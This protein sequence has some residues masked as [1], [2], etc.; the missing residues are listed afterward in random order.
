MDRRRNP[1]TPNAGATP[2]SL[3]GRGE[4]LEDFDLLLDRLAA[5]HTEQSMLISGLRGVGKT[6][7]LGQFREHAL[8]KKW[9]TVETEFA[10]DVAFGPRIVQ[11]SRQALF[12]VAPRSRWRAAAHRAAGVLSAFSLKV[13]PDGSLT[14]GLDVE[15]AQG[16]GDSGDLDSDLTALLLALGE[17]AREHKTG[18]V[19][20]LDEMQDLAKHELAAVIAA[21]H[22]TV[23][24]T[25]PI[26][27]VGAGLPQ[28]PRLAAEAKS[29]AERLFR[30][31]EIGRLDADAAGQALADPAGPLGVHFAPEALQAIVEYT[32]GYPFFLQVYGKA[33]WNF[34]ESSPVSTADV[35]AVRQLVDRELDAGFFRVRTDRASVTEL[36]YLRALAEL[37]P[38]AQR[39]GEVAKL[40]RRS[41]EQ[42]GT[43]RSRL[44]AK[45]LLYSP[46][47]GLAGFT[48]P[49]F[50]EYLRRSF[51]LDVAAPRTRRSRARRTT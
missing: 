23:Q 25:V 37:G 49:L 4:Q 10:R 50:D 47:Y 14:A 1:Y 33:V 34:T 26:T 16:N 41:V 8:A 42:L 40:M 13:E 6:V 38:E 51:P 43:T 7:L 45:G 19:F 9:V 12:D 15:P 5:G 18:V 44:I 3:V 2:P 39:A 46:A 17:A 48:V 29:Y 32:Q 28:L 22:K 21:V 20:L 36:A 30:F 35:M 31:P 24:R 11:L 27:V